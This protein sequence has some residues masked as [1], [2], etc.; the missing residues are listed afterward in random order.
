MEANALRTLRP[1]KDAEGQTDY[2]DN[3][4]SCCYRNESEH[5]E[6]VRLVTRE[7]TVWERT[8]LPFQGISF[9][10][11]KYSFLEVLDCMTVTTV[12]SDTISCESLSVSHVRTNF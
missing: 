6:I 7:Q 4:L 10:A 12:R 11:Y 8:I 9:H 1:V 5:I 2:S 3:A